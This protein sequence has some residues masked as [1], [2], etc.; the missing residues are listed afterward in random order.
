[1][2]TKNVMAFVIIVAAVLIGMTFIMSSTASA[3]IAAPGAGIVRSEINSSVFAPRP[4]LGPRPFIAPRPFLGPRPFVSPFFN[5]FLFPR[6]NPFFDDDLFF[7]EPDFPFF[8]D[9]DV[10]FEG[11]E[12]EDD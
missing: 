8:F 4:F 9:D 12:D 2:K 6:F 7:E 3:A 5:P 1:M 11:F 10:E